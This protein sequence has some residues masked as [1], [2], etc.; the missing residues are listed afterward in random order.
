MT[1]LYSVYIIPKLF[2]DAM[3]L[4][5]I[6]LFIE[7]I[8]GDFAVKRR[9]QQS[10]WRESMINSSLAIHDKRISMTNSQLTGAL[11]RRRSRDKIKLINHLPENKL[12]SKILSFVLIS[13]NLKFENKTIIQFIY[14]YL[15]KSKYC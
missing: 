12:R 5:L 3:Q 2:H 14:F 13:C 6:I 4:F 11:I 7:Y 15:L 9:T 8:F 1:N 10:G